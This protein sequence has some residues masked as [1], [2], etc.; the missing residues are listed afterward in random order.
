MKRPAATQPERRYHRI[1]QR[2]FCRS[3]QRPGFSTTQYQQ[4]HHL[5]DQR[6]FVVLPPKTIDTDQQNLTSA[7]L[8]S[9]LILTIN[10]E[11]GDSVT[12]DLSTLMDNKDQQQLSLNGDTIYLTNGGYVLLPPKMVDTDRQNLTYATLD[13]NNILT[14]D[15]ENGDSV[16]VDLE[17]SARRQGHAEPDFGY[18]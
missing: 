18:Y 16:T 7:T 8:D 11:N 9:N 14:I 6:R 12:V 5:P 10:I 2:W 15:I 1:N 3:A 13:S 4:R 17:Q